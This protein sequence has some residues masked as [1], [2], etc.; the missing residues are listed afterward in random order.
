MTRDEM[1]LLMGLYDWSIQATEREIE[2]N[3]ETL[4]RLKSSS[5]TV[6]AEWLP[7]SK[8]PARSASL[9]LVK[10]FHLPALKLKGEEFTTEDQQLVDDF[11]NFARFKRFA[12]KVPSATVKARGQ[13]RKGVLAEALRSRLDPILG[14]AELLEGDVWKYETVE[15]PFRVATYV[16][17]GGR[18]PLRYSHKMI[19]R[20]GRIF[21]ETSLLHWHGIATETAWDSMGPKDT[22]SSVE[23]LAELCKRF[24][25]A[26]ETIKTSLA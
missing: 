5:A 24:M 13:I 4:S 17:L 22:D 25:A 9:A 7:A 8:A 20:N 14:K 2:R 11:I 6:Y 26:L 12:A 19:A 16:D 15:E 3:C 23:L 10:R 21:C 1:H 18:L